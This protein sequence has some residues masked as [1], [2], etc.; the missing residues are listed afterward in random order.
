MGRKTLVVTG[1]ALAAVMALGLV[2]CGDDDSLSSPAADSRGASSGETSAPAISERSRADALFSGSGGTGA[3]G[4]TSPAVASALDRKIVFNG[5]M[6]LEADD[7]G[8]TFNDVARLA[9]VA[10]GFVEQSNF[11]AA[12]SGR[13]ASLTIRVP[14]ERYQQTLADI[15]SLSG[16]KVTSESARSVEVTEE[17]T[18]LE[19]RLRNLERTESQYLTLLEKATT[20][21][22]ILTLTDRLDGVRLQIEQVQGRI[23]VLDHLTD[24]ATIDVAV[25]PVPAATA[26]SN[27]G[28]PAIGDALANAWHTSVEAARYFAVGGVYL[29]M[30][31]AWLAIP[32][33]IAVFIATRVLRHRSGAG[34]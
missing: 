17:Y 21:Q 19:S 31:A 23:A 24:L 27:D 25:S 33:A 26:K 9:T 16:V 4:G 20:V 5:S 34:V 10:G 6:Y 28:P 30:A 8:R 32:V 29:A 2:A 14:A 7:V 13:G 15:R 11:A 18:D 22:D 1:G 12:T 3:D